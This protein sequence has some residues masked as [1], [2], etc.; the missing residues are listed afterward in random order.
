MGSHCVLFEALYFGVPFRDRLLEHYATNKYTGD[1]ESMLTCLARDEKK[2]SL[3]ATNASAASAPPPL[4]A[5]ARVRVSGNGEQA[6]E[7]GG[8]RPGRSV[9]KQSMGSP[10]LWGRRPPDR[11][12]EPR[13]PP[14][15]VGLALLG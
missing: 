13:A 4:P 3:P 8:S 2:S 1:V 11:A 9:D 5:A 12:V 14:R 7:S 6:S 15:R 10:E